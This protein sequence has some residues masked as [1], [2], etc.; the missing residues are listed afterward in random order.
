MKTHI[1]HV[2]LPIS[3]ETILM[4]SGTIGEH[5]PALIKGNNFSCSVSVDSKTEADRI[6]NL[7]RKME[8]FPYH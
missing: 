7:Y 8:R 2:S 4:V 3:E 6:F 1:L 5:S